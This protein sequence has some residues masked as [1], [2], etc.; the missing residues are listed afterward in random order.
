[1]DQLATVRQGGARCRRSRVQGCS[2]PRYVCENLIYVFVLLIRIFPFPSGYVQGTAD[3]VEG[4]KDSIVGA[5]TGDKQQQTSGNAQH[6]K[7]QL[8]QNINSS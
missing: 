8:Q 2:S 5:V 3:R 1:M 4:K 7:G 6:D